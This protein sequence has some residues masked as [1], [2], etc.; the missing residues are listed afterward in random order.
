MRKNMNAARLHEMFC[1]WLRSTAMLEEVEI[2]KE[3]CD[4]WRYHSPESDRTQKI[5]GVISQESSDLLAETLNE[6]KQ[7]IKSK[8][9]YQ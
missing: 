5:A 8:G 1:S 4:K 9:V 7:T 2:Y 6:S 3:D